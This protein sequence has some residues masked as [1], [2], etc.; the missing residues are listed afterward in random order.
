M[1]LQLVGARE[2]LAAEQPVADE[3]PLAGM[4]PEVRL[5]VARL[6]V[7]LAAAGYVAAIV[8]TYVVCVCLFFTIFFSLS[9]SSRR[10][11]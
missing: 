9:L 1:P 4:P 11:L 6:P 5:Q 2:A 8:L 7:H 10:I 3:R